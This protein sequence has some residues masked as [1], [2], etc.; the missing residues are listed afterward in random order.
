MADRRLLILGLVLAA[1]SALFLLWNLR[2]PVGFILGLRLT[3]LAALCAVGTA[4]GTATVLFQTIAA[5][6]LLTPG[7]VGFD[8]LFVFIQTMLVLGLGG[9]GYAALPSLAQFGVET[10]TLVAAAMALFGVLLRRG[11]DDILRMILTGV[12]LGVLLRGL[13]GLAQRLLDPSEFAIVQQ[14]SFATFGAVDRTQLAIAGPI[15]ILSFAAALRLARLLDLAALGRATALPLGLDFDRVVFVTLGLVALLVA[16]STALVGPITFL[17]LLAASLAHAILPTWRHDRLLPGA[18][19]IGATI[20][21]S[22]QFV[23][24]RL[25]GLQSTLTVI[26]EFLGGLLFLLL[27]LRRPRP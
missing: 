14:A 13:A 25:L 7:I 6:R 17:G 9:L 16:V 8:A 2:A 22:G 1:V 12:I 20:L 5:N 18:A 24:E 15:L 23:F 10:L 26:V 27:V 19:L 21:V 3:K 4:I 11:A